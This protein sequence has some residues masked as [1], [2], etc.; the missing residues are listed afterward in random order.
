MTLENTLFGHDQDDLEGPKYPKTDYLEDLGHLDG[1]FFHCNPSYDTFFS[2][3]FKSHMTTRNISNLNK[4]F[5]F[6]FLQT[7]VLTRD[8]SNNSFIQKKK[9]FYPNFYIQFPQFY[10]F[11]TSCKT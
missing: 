8:T 4:L 9:T 11:K 1:D 3:V 6:S 7:L 2:N 5:F 10:S